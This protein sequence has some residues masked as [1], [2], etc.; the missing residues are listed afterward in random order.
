MLTN[1]SMTIALLLLAALLVSRPGFAQEEHEE[2]GHEEHHRYAIA[3]FVGSTRVG[4]E[5]E[6]TVG[7]EA[8]IHLNR[9]W[10]IGAVIERAER[11]R[12]ST[13]LMVGV[14]WRPTGEGFRLQLGL[15]R[16]DPSGKEETV[17]RTGVGYEFE[18]RNRWFVKPYF[19]VDF[20]E[21]EDNEEVFGV[22][23]GRGF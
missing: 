22:Y 5:N 7:I 19:A 4:S 8:G 3:G 17:V 18:L 2:S 9:K 1:S 23:V 6:F 14:G 10:A 20:I 12:H 16:K 21:H 13:L 11:E 15:G